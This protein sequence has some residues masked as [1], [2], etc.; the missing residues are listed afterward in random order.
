MNENIILAIVLVSVFLLGASVATLVYERA[1]SPDVF[2]SAENNSSCENRNLFQT[3]ECL[4]QEL[5]IFYNYN[6]TNVDKKMDLEQLKEEGG[7]CSHYAHWYVDRAKQ[8]GFYAE[9]EVIEINEENSH[10][11]AVISDSSG[12]CILD[13]LVIKCTELKT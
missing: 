10:A 2:Y 11:F 6:I 4:R 3:A 12:Y 5:D 7:V 1:L 13:Q 9:Y 8:L